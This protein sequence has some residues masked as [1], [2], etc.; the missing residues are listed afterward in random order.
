M[1]ILSWFVVFFL[2]GMG[3][4]SGYRR[5][6]SNPFFLEGMIF[7]I[8][9]VPMIF[10]SIKIGTQISYVPLLLLWLEYILIFKLIL[11]SRDLG[12]LGFKC[13][14]GRHSWIE[15]RQ[16]LDGGWSRSCRYGCGYEE[17]HYFKPSVGFISVV[18]KWRES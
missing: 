12:L 10:L 9:I 3:A 13:L 14:F 18:V 2:F 1:W 6:V 5:N 15:L 4:T 8:T 16:P 17:V 11:V 7:G